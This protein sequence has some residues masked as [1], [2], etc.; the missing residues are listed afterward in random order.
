LKG[1][2]ITDFFCWFRGGGINGVSFG[3]I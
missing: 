1:S 3:F 2:T